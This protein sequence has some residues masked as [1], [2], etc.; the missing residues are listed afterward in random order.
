MGVLISIVGACAW[1]VRKHMNAV[2]WAIVGLMILLELVMEKPIWH[3]LHR[4]GAIALDSSTGY[5]RYRLFDAFVRHFT[6]WAPLGLNSTGYWGQQLDDVTNTFIAQAVNG[7]LLGLILIITLFVQLFLR[8]GKLLRAY[9]GRR[10]NE[11]Y[12]WAL[13]VT[14]FTH[15]AMM[16]AM[17]YLWQMQLPWYACFAMIAGAPVPSRV[18]KARRGR[19]S[20]SEGSSRVPASHS[21]DVPAT[22]L[23]VGLLHRRSGANPGSSGKSRRGSIG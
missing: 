18:P 22:P 23:G 13:G 9:R 17:G 6:D 1:V 10:V 5:H 20:A 3:L 4:V 15:T 12:L 21:S 11:I 19:V 2:R 7:G 14:L 16:N 8:N